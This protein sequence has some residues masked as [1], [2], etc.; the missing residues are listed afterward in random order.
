M[1]DKF[2]RSETVRGGDGASHEGIGYWTY[3]VEYLLKFWQL[4]ADVTGEK[5]SS[6][7][8]K[9]GVTPV[10]SAFLPSCD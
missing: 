3:G 8:W 9:T 2:R 7:W 10:A 6:A 5:P 1:L 4:S